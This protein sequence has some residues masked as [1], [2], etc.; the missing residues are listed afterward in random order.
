MNEGKA[1][2]AFDQEF[3][4]TLRHFDSVGKALTDKLQR[5]ADDNELLLLELRE[6]R[7]ETRAEFRELQAVMKFFLMRSWIAEFRSQSGPF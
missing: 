4:E 3:I 1:L 6:F 7:S 5:V 2:D